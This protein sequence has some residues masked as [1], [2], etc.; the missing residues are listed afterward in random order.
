MRQI[1]THCFLSIAKE[2]NNEMGQF[3]L[4]G[5]DLMVDIDLK[6]HLLE[7]RERPST[8]AV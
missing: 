1:M 4:V 7:A 3:Q 5:F 8:F 6:V 2:V